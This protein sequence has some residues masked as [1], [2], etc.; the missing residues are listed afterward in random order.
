MAES[1][2]PTTTMSWSRKKNPSQVAHQETPWPLKLLL[3]GQAELAVGGAGGDD[4]GGRLVGLAGAGDHALEVAGEV[5]LG[6]VVEDHLGAEPLGLL[7][8]FVHQLRA[9]DAV[10]EAG[11]VLDLGGVHQRAAGG[12]RPPKTSG[13]SPARAA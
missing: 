5:D 11:E 8:Q 3:L 1:P 9:L 6:D 2:P 13:F 7:L 12:D 10:G 4:D